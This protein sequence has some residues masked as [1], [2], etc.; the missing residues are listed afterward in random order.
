M[1]DGR[2]PNRGDTVYRA[3]ITR[4]YEPDPT[5]R[6][7]LYRDGGVDIEVR[8]AYDTP[9]PARA[10]ATKVLGEYARYPLRGRTVTAKVQKGTITWEDME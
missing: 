5:S 9:G 10:A 4:T 3:V 6:Y 2:N 1:G 7:P 8:G